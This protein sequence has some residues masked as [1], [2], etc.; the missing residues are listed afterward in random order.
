MISELYFLDKN[1]SYQ[2]IDYFKLIDFSNN[3]INNI[4]IFLRSNHIKFTF[5]NYTEEKYTYENYIKT[6]TNINNQTTE[7]IQSTN[8]INY[9]FQNNCLLIDKEYKNIEITQFPNLYK[10][11]SIDINN[12]TQYEIS[13]FNIKT[14]K[15]DKITLF[16]KRN[17]K[18]FNQVYLS[19]IKDNSN[20]LIYTLPK[21]I[22]QILYNHR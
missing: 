7:T 17:Q 21:Y 12:I 15:M 22:Q 8:Y 1:Y 10:Y 13:Q 18:G 16:I 5:F 14:K 9:A 11:D 19:F 20:H 4:I 2:D 6:I 3:D